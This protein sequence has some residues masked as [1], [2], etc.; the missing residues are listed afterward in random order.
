MQ[1]IPE[2]PEVSIGSLLKTDGMTPPELSQIKQLEQLLNDCLRMNPEARMGAG[3]AL[4]HE[5]LRHKK[6]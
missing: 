3:Q 4:K 1:V 2:H 5:F 6:P